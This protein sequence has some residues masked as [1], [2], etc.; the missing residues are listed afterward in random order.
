[1][2]LI[3]Q[4]NEKPNA[5]YIGKTHEAWIN[6]II[7][8]KSDCE[9]VKKWTHELYPNVISK[10][11]N[12]YIPESHIEKSDVYI[13]GKIKKDITSLNRLIKDGISAKCGTTT[14]AGQIYRG[15]LDSAIKLG[16][17]DKDGALCTQHKEWL[18]EGKNLIDL[19][20][21]KE[22]EFREFYYNIWDKLKE[23]CLFGSATKCSAL[24]LSNLKYSET[25]NKLEVTE[26]VLVTKEQALKDFNIISNKDKVKVNLNGRGTVQSGYIFVQRAGG[27]NGEKGAEDWQVRL[28]RNRYIQWIKENRPET[29]WIE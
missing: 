28:D 1:M 25:T 9:I 16:F 14:M 3:A 15:S 5:Y 24:L 21:F 22:Q 11:F 8:E 10:E 19:H 7:N 27:S 17:I 4:F 20:N 13:S 23:V 26:T 18:S 6:K 2:N 29:V 12:S